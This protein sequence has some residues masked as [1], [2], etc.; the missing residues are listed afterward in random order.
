M[1]VDDRPFETTSV[2]GQITPT[3]E[4]LDRLLAKQTL[5]E[6]YDVEEQPFARFVYLMRF[7]ADGIAG[8]IRKLSVGN[9]TS[10]INDENL[11]KKTEMVDVTYLTHDLGKY[12]LGRISY[13]P[14]KFSSVS[15]ILPR[16]RISGGKSTL[17]HTKPLEKNRTLFIAQN[18]VLVLQS[19]ENLHTKFVLT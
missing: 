17:F 18:P 6:L 3:A 4:R 15:H 5:E 10:S 13:S 8:T 12:L 11:Q 9:K 19:S 14:S 1:A 16:R 7:D 2:P